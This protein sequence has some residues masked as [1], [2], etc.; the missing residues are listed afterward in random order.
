MTIKEINT[1]RNYV[2]GSA[3]G[4]TCAV[5]SFVVGRTRDTRMALYTK[6]K[7]KVGRV[8]RVSVDSNSNSNSLKLCRPVTRLLPN[9]FQ[10][11]LH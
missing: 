2:V 4:L 1:I 3:V 10:Q 7:F 5:V 8:S 11:V 9:G 6:I